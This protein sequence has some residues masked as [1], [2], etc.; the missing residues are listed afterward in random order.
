MGIKELI[1]NVVLADA[2]AIEAAQ[3]ALTD[4]KSAEIS[5]IWD[6]ILPG[7]DNE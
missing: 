2:G 1:N 6:E 7:E 4:I 3:A 5:I